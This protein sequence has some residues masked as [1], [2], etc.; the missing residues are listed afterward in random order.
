VDARDFVG[1]SAVIHFASEDEA[2]AH[3]ARLNA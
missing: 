1:A 2:E 3:A